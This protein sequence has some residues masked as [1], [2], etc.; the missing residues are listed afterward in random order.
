MKTRIITLLIA[1]TAII[2]SAEAQTKINIH[3]GGE[4]VYTLPIAE[5]DSVGFQKEAVTNQH[6]GYEFVDLGLS[7]K[8]AT[9]N[10]GATTPEG[11]GNNYAWGETTPQ[12][13]LATEYTYNDNP[14]VLPLSAD[15]ANVNW[16]GKWRMPT[17]EEM[18]ELMDTN[19]STWTW[20]TQNGVSGYKVTSKKNGNSIFLPAAANSGC[21]WSSSIYPGSTFYAYC[22]M[23]TSVS[24]NCDYSQRNYGQSVRAVCDIETVTPK[25]E[26]AIYKNDEVIY[27]QPISEIDS[28]KFD[29]GGISI[30]KYYRIKNVETGLYLNAENYD[31][32]YTGTRGGVTCVAYAQ[33]ADQIFKFEESGENYKLKT[34]SGYYIYCQQWIVD[35]QTN[36]VELTFDDNGNGTY[37]IKFGSNYFGVSQ[38]KGIY[39]PYCTQYN[40][41]AT[42]V[43]EDA[44]QMPIY[45]ISVS[46][47]NGGT[48]TAS[49]SSMA[50]G[51][52]VTL[53]ATPASGYRF[54][55]WTVNGTEVSTENIFI[56]T[57][58][59]N[60][61]YVANFEE[62]TSDSGISLTKEYR[63]KDVASGMYLNA[64]NNITHVGGPNGGVNC[65]AYAEDDRQIFTFEASGNNYYLKSKSGYYIYCQQ[66]NVDALTYGSELT[67]ID[68]P[69][70][71]YYIKN[72]ANYFKVELVEGV[73]YPFGDAG[74]DLRATWVLEQVGGEEPEPIPTYT[75]TVSATEGGSVTTSAESVEEGGSVILTATP[76][77]GY[78]FVNWTLNNNVVSV[79][80]PYIATITENSAFVA[81]FEE[82][83][84]KVKYNVSVSV[85]NTDMGS[86]TAS[87]SSVEEGG[88]VTLTATAKSGYEFVNWTL[89]G[90]VVSTENPYTVTVTANSE[91]VANFKQKV[92]S[93]AKISLTQYFRIKDITSGKY[94]NAAN[95]DAHTGGQNG[96]VNCI[97]YDDSDDQKFMFEPSD[98]NFK[99][100]TKSGYYIYCQ[101]YNV[102][103]LTTATVLTFEVNENGEYYIKNSNGYFKVE[104][105][106]G[107]YYPF[108][109]ASSSKK[110]TF[111]L[112]ETGEATNQVIPTYTVEAKANTGGT[113]SASSTTV[114]YGESV[115]LTATPK[116]GYLFNYWS[117]TGKGKV[118]TE[119]PYS[120]I[121]TANSQ[122]YANFVKAVY[123]VTVSATEGGAA[124]VSA[125]SVEHGTSVTLTATPDE[126]YVFR[127]WTLNGEVVSI[128]SSYTRSITTNSEFVANFIK[129]SDGVTGSENGHDYVDLGLP[130]GTRWATC[131][132][133]ASTPEEKGS[134]YAWGE[135]E[136]KESY[137]NITYK[138][139]GVY[140]PTKYVLDPVGSDFADE[141]F[142]DNKIALESS[143]DAA[144]VNWGGKWRMPTKTEA[145]ELVEYCTWTS[146]TQ[147]GVAG[148]KI[149]SN[150]NGNSIF[151]PKAG[152]YVG[153]D[154][155]FYS[156]GW[157]YW[158][159]SLDIDDN[160]LAYYLTGNNSGIYDRYR[161]QAIRA[162]CPQKGE[163][164]PIIIVGV[165]SSSGGKAA[166][167]SNSVAH[168]GTV[169]LTATPNN[170]FAFKNWTLNGEV[171]STEST[172]TATVT[173]VDA[174]ISTYRHYVANFED[175]SG[176][177]YEYV[178]LG[179]SV[180]WATYN[181]GATDIYEAGD[182]FAW[183]ETEVKN[184]Y[185]W[186]T[187]KYAATGSWSYL[188]RITKYS[189][190]RVGTYGPADG[191]DTLEPEDDAAQVYWGDNW[192][193]PTKTELKELFDNCTW[194]TSKI[195]GVYVLEGT[196]KINGNTIC[197]ILPGLTETISI[198]S[199]SLIANETANG[200]DHENA[201][202]AVSLLIGNSSFSYLQNQMV[203]DSY[204]CGARYVRAV[205]E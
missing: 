199:S 173:S 118:S 157:Y 69:D 12:S 65:V 190:S 129:Y 8:W 126:G 125:E 82:F 162:V 194:G 168:N 31:F 101:S 15:A 72:G 176:K 180:K 95:Y 166:T 5:L 175:V 139:S 136:T 29:K 13:W 128:K 135:T 105:V 20:T 23:F 188:K 202:Y 90:E 63:I 186:G 201:P 40:N 131:N 28:I 17:Y 1:I 75:V 11:Y 114:A 18:N 33:D 78:R 115:T 181:V 119:N 100:K 143:D 52:S 42:W 196:S 94:L 146:W 158:T 97:D 171:V 191:K 22:L 54:V 25:T 77:T 197:F 149:T 163:G 60:A 127:D 189:T 27:S 62:R 141:E 99:L 142:I 79:S 185:K 16:G 7:V 102:D 165:S 71:T 172:Y 89:N 50:K 41:R 192:R 169:I 10:V 148:Y 183:G 6:N 2:G 177:E 9:C 44:T 74:A 34:N 96:G 108:C 61:L 107:T 111:I 80:N 98:T 151:L 45:T 137:T 51:G 106:N 193:M 86:V 88:S 3:Q 56:A 147:N 81:N 164:A 154:G 32:H 48:A 161:G 92:V 14:A 47:T 130:S 87:A 104:Q 178:D 112:E 187:Y 174:N 134:Y 36:G 179:L 59:A 64:E 184:Y 124:T 116:T 198:W 182:K 132:I 204:R 68:N 140:I 200:I 120:P 24:V 122:F 153:T 93:G 155:R 121:I 152:G 123:N 49:A 66:W 55:N 170:G 160:D 57:I 19:N 39:Y 76:E 150:I 4:V 159:S 30:S 205:C 203:Y 38:D 58:T 91:F 53:I 26:V 156:N 21:Y 133:G 84:E 85:N 73:Y 144:T 103:A 67:F 43:L 37:N 46:A 70:G 110:A 83:V 138:Y 145:K 117:K 35:A 195:N 109:D 113:A 167:S